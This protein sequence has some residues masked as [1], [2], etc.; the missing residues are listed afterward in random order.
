MMVAIDFTGSNGD[1]TMPNSLHYLSNTAQNE[2][3]RA[4]W[5]VGSILDNYDNSKMYPVFGFGGKPD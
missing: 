5:G 4:I 3:E 2:Y 1:Y